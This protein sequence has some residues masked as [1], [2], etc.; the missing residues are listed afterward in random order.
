MNIMSV[1]LGKEIQMLKIPGKTPPRTQTPGKNLGYR[2][3]G[4]G[5]HNTGN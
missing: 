3:K 2:S 1:C 5:E 4:K